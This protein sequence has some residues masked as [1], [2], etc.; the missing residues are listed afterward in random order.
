MAKKQIPHYSI[1]TIR[2]NDRNPDEIIAYRFNQYL[3]T[4]EYLLQPHRHSFFHMVYFTRGA[5]KHF[6]DFVNFPVQPG[7]IYFMNPGQVHHW[8]FSEEADG[9]IVNFSDKFYRML[10]DPEYLQQF[11]FF[12]GN[13][14]EQVIQLSEKAKVQVEELFVRILDEIGHTRLHGIDMLRCLLFE[15]FITVSRDVN[16]EQCSQV[17][18]SG[19]MIMRNFRKLVE[20]HFVDKKLPKNYAP[21]LHVTPNYL[22]A[23]SKSLVGKS[24]GEI[25]RERVL[26]EA[27]RL[28][29]NAGVSISEIAYQLNFRDNAYFSRFFKKYTGISPEEFRKQNHIE[30]VH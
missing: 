7:Q 28:L 12:N 24:A 22:N 10:L 26:L 9:Y 16:A 18:R 17:S 3:T 6:I 20:A 25:I 19:M 30:A 14:Q 11:F 21:M 15:I 5:G 27:K 23:L 2:G 4:R 1:K 13:C 8:I 29:V